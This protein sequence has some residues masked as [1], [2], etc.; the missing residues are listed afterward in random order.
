M[1][2]RTVERG[3]TKVS[4]TVDP[5]LMQAVDTFVAANPETDRGRVIEDALT[6]W[7]AHQQE[8]AMEAQFA[9]PVSD[10]VRAER[11][12]WRSIQAAAA[13]RIFSR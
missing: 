4:V 8:L 12:A 1:A 7:L 13:A 9:E 3:R 10:E 11:A 6:L 2:Q 5:R